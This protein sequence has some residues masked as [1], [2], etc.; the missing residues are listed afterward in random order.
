MI[1]EEIRNI[2]ESPKDLRKFGI[3]VGSVFIL[4]TLLLFWKQNSLYF[5]FG[6][7][8]LFLL[9]TG[10]I[11]PKILRPINKGWMT[12]SILLGWVSTRVILTIL[13]FIILTPLSFL[14]KLLG[15]NFLDLRIDYDRLSYWEA[16]EKKK[17]SPP[18]YEKQF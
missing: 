3:T 12:I 2:K 5:Y 11:F 18:D 1:T 10:L 4:L 16:R 9:L 6:I 7:I 15:K 13:F 8:G 17:S 14:S